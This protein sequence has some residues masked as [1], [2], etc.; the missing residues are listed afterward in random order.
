METEE[1]DDTKDAVTEV[2]KVPRAKE[3]Q[4]NLSQATTDSLSVLADAALATSDAT[5]PKYPT[6]FPS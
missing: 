4:P 2:Q 3:I 1:K 5:P 6:K